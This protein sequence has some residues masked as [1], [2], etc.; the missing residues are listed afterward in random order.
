MKGRTKKL[1]LKT[2]REIEKRSLEKVT[3]QSLLEKQKKINELVD[4]LSKSRAFIVLDLENLETKIYKEFKRELEENKY[5]VKA[6]KNKI[7]LKALEKAGLKGGEELSK[8]LTKPVAIVFSGSDNVF[9]LA[10]KIFS[11][12]AYTKIKPG[13]KA[14]YDIVVPAGPTDIPP[15]P[16]MSVFGRL[17]IPVQPREGKIHVIRD[18]V[19][20]REGQE[21][22]SELASLL[23][24][25]DI[26]PKVVKPKI[27]VGY[28]EGILFS[29]DSLKL[30]LLKYRATF[31]EA[32]KN[33]LSLA[34]EIVIPD[35]GVLR[36]VLM[37]AY[38]RAINLASEVGV[39]SSENIM[40][41]LL[42]ALAR[43][44]V[45]AQKIGLIKPIEQVSQQEVRKEEVKEEPKEE[46]KEEVSEETIAEG[47]SA[48]FG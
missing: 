37:R 22:S 25:L 9:V 38:S 45:L 20:A 2:L 41:L 47:L 10:D 30:D 16:M 4:L 8:Y 40:Y 12:H 3:K 36:I 44:S 21:I 35:I 13:E 46:K 29:E 31:E 18:T 23:A 1:Y 5:M 24:K 17:K 34:S 6:V 14:P 43:A 48:L 27:I 7:F 39:I 19:V 28:E 26:L 32:M 33:A 11:L 15:G 42:R